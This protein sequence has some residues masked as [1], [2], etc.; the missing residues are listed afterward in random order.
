MDQELKEK[1]VKALRSGEY[2]QGEG[3]LFMNGAYCCL[4][5]LN[6]CS[7]ISTED[8]QGI[9]IGNTEALLFPNG[10]YPKDR[11]SDPIMKLMEM[12]DSGSTFPE[13]ADWIEKNL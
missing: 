6:V 13:I 2:P 1:W 11:V 5:V 4:G 7:G 8:I 10:D 9:A 12:N 3:F